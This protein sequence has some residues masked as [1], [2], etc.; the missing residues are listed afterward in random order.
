MIRE[1]LH[2]QLFSARSLVF[3]SSGFVLTSQKVLDVKFEANGENF[4]SVLFRLPAEAEKS[5]PFHS[6]IA[7]LFSS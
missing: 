6:K 4:S 5:S 2:I 7:A 3:F 1:I